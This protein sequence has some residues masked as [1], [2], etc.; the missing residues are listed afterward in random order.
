MSS[1]DCGGHVDHT[2]AGFVVFLCS[3]SAIF[4]ASFAGIAVLKT[5][6]P[7]WLPFGVEGLEVT[8]P[9]INTIVLV[10]FSSVIWLAK[11]ALAKRQL[12]RFR[13]FWLITIAMSAHLVAGQAIQM[14][15]P[16][17]W[18]RKRRV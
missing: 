13:L 15:W 11:K 18:S 4:L 1:V 14:A 9:L 17:L 8:L 10:S 7:Q 2:L 5:T 6:T 12:I 16:G 3:E